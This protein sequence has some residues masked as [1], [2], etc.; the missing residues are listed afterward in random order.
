M[1]TSINK[2]RTTDNISIITTC[3]QSSITIIAEDKGVK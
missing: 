1:H 2:T 3:E